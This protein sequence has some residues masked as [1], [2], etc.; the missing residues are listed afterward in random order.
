VGRAALGLVALDHPERGAERQ[1]DPA[2]PMK[3]FKDHEAARQRHDE[4][5]AR[6]SVH[7]SSLLVPELP[8]AEAEIAFLNHFL[9]KRG[10]DR[11]ACR[12]TSIDAQGEKIRTALHMLREPR[13]HRF[14][15]SHMA[16]GAASH[17]VEFFAA[18]NLVVPFPAVMIN[19]EGPGFL[20][21]VHAFNRVLNDVFEDDA[22]NAIQ[23]PEASIDVEA[24]AETFVVFMAGAERCRGAL[25]FELATPRGVRAA[26]VELD[27][28]RLCPRV[29]ALREV[30]ADPRDRRP[31]VLRI[32]Q[33]RQPMFYGRLLA[34]RRSDD[35][36]TANHS[37]YDSS[38]S[39]EYWNDDEESWRTYPMFDGLQTIVRMYPVMSPG[40]LATSI[41]VNDRR[42]R[43]LARSETW[44]IE[45]PGARFLDIDLSRVLASR[46]VAATDTATF[47]VRARPVS[48]RAPTR[49][50]HQLLYGRGGLFASINVSL[51]HRSMFVPNGKT[52][53]VWGQIPVGGGIHPHIGIVASTP[54]GPACDVQVTLYDETGPRA[55]RT[56][57]LVPNGAIALDA[58]DFEP[59]SIDR[60]SS[61]IWYVA[62][63][64][65][66][67][68]CG[69]TVSRHA[70]SGHS[71][72][73]HSF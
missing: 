27:V 50:N 14:A 3:P 65:R 8:G 29:I 57:H 63:G 56:Q 2:R 68:L 64:S 33:P 37:Y 53:F 7:R 21:T 47:T 1:G 72:G 58:G 51:R 30:F 73:E 15:L 66:P 59:D 42:G 34:G 23:T 62:H 28:P 46:G 41:E 6:D 55:S 52:G 22:V 38:A 48:G 19:H 35:A 20:N 60:R 12:I 67:D 4:H 9:V 49:I 69:F 25:E 13:V 17:L 61:S 54:G 10:Y 71:S 18:E 36:F 31:G 45:S 39:H 11:V 26:A 32:R 24:G 44:E 16:Q 40:R 5:P 43:A 70:Q